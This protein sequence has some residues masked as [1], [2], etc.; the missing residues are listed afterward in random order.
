MICAIAR[1]TA[2]NV[3]LTLLLLVG[4]V[5]APSLTAAMSVNSI[6]NKNMAE[7]C[8]GCCCCVNPESDTTNSDNDCQ[9]NVSEN[10]FPDD[11]EPAV[12][13][14]RPQSETQAPAGVTAAFMAEVSLPDNDH[15]QSVYIFD[16]YPPPLYIANCAFLI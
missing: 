5:A 2:V 16:Q 11:P 9:C 13:S 15:F 6:P 14:V 10:E 4:L 3:F 8:C 7:P 12:E 1:N